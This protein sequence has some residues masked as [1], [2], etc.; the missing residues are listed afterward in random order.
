VAEDNTKLP[1]LT[2]PTRTDAD[3]KKSASDPLSSRQAP[4]TPDE[5]LQKM[6]KKFEEQIQKT[7]KVESKNSNN[8]RK[9]QLTHF[10]VRTKKRKKEPPQEIKHLRTTEKLRKPSKLR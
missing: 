8:L 3:E 9:F 10:Q 7:P 6:K 2:P 4:S 5:K 1:S